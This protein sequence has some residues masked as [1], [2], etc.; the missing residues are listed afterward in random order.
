[1]DYNNGSVYGYD[2]IQSNPIMNTFDNPY[3]QVPRVARDQ[4]YAASAGNYNHIGSTPTAHRVEPTLPIN[5][6]IVNPS[7]Q[8]EGMCNAPNIYSDKNGILLIFIFILILMVVVNS[9]TL[10]HMTSQLK[11]LRYKTRDLQSR[12]MS[13]TITPTGV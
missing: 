7:T 3:L 4:Q 8:H 13:A 10:K 11:H 5:M 1:M 12:V 6:P 9:V 2:Q